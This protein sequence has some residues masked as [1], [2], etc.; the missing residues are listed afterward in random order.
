MLKLDISNGFLFI[1]NINKKQKN[2]LRCIANQ[3]GGGGGWVGVWGGGGMER[4]SN[5]GGHLQKGHF[6]KKKKRLPTKGNLEAK[7]Y[8]I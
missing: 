7:I 5:C 1:Y 6:L 4:L 3:G 8:N 2:N